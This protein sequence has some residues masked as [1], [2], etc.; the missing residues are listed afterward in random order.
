MLLGRRVFFG[1]AV[2]KRLSKLNT[3]F[4]PEEE[5]SLEQLKYIE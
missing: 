2:K 3:G 5:Q 1:N 4:S